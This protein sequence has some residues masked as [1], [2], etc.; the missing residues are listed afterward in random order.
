M[1]NL[2]P[3]PTIIR[4]RK[5]GGLRVV[6]ALLTCF[7][8]VVS[9]VGAVI[10]F[11]YFIVPA[12]GLIFTFTG[13]LFRFVWQGLRDA[14]LI[15]IAL[16]VG[17]IKMIRAVICVVLG[18]WDIVHTE[19]TFA[20]LR[21]FEAYNRTISFC[22]DNP[23]Q[24]FGIKPPNKTQEHAV[25]KQVQ[26][27]VGT[28]SRPKTLFGGYS[29]TG[30]LPSG[31]SGAKL[32][33]AKSIDSGVEVVIKHF[34]IG[35]GSQ[36]PQIVRESKAMECA[37]KLGLV[38]EHHLDD[39]NFWYAMPFHNGDHLGI[40][41]NS[42]HTQSKTLSHNQFKTILGH[43][44]DLLRTLKTYHDAGL[45]HKDVKPDNIIIHGGSAHLVDLGLITPLASHMTLTTHGTEYYRDPELV[46]QAMRGV[47]VHQINGAKFD[48]YGAGAVLYFMLEN[49]FP[50]H[51]ALSDFNTQSPEG[52]R[53]IV[54]RAMSDYD[55]RYNSIEEMLKDVE[56]VLKS[57]NIGSVRPADLP[58]MHGAEVAPET[59]SITHRRLP[60]STPSTGGGPF[61]KKQHKTNPLGLVVLVL[62][63]FVGV[64]L[65]TN[66]NN[67]DQ[68]TESTQTVI[69]EIHPPDGM[70]LIINELHNSLSNNIHKEA[71]NKIAELGVAGWELVN[72]PET[73]ARVRILLPPDPT[74]S[75]IP[76]HKLNNENLAG[77]LLI[78]EGTESSPLF[79]FID[80]NGSRP[81]P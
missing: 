50:A 58:S 79:Y 17:T 4:K 26:E 44:Q 30:T 12:L 18:R 10:L 25:V 23:L 27:F 6:T 70:V 39:Q 16:F 54:R 9:L 75:P 55:K 80:Q 5:Y 69:H 41:T 73:E 74:T 14:L 37:K 59:P 40:I 8:T 24:L 63:V 15:P 48:V 49:T 43:E 33:V 38:I 76:S 81:L 65:V 35:S 2:P 42:L 32:Y 29:I 67:T 45:W 77:V 72:N 60:R 66:K 56:S 68:R 62:A 7:G 53:W 19:T 46:R 78:K 21:F 47:K 57:K 1:R 64:A 13:R 11:V 52:L 36:L 34:D 28:K 22:I 31:G 51:G 61:P 20:K 71:S 3:T